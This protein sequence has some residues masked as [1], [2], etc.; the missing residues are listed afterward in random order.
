MS[1]NIYTN[2]DSL[3]NIRHGNI[4]PLLR[5]TKQVSA[6][7]IN[8]LPPEARGLL[9]R[10]GVLATKYLNGECVV[11]EGCN[12]VLEITDNFVDNYIGG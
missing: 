12:P 10:D 3:L 6:D 5:T 2:L 9:I 8:S 7:A 1:S 11:K 4:L